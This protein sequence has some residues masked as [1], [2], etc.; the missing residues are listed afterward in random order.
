MKKPKRLFKKREAGDEDIILA[1]P[2]TWG[3]KPALLTSPRVKDLAPY[4][5]VMLAALAEGY[6]QGLEE[7][8][9]LVVWRG[10]PYAK[11]QGL[12]KS[13]DPLI[14]RPISGPEL[15]RLTGVEPYPTNTAAEAL[16]RYTFAL[17]N[18]DG[19]GPNISLDMTEEGAVL[20][21]THS[22]TYRRRIVDLGDMLEAIAMLEQLTGIGRND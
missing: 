17:A 4:G 3:E 20:A 16:P 1:V 6:K 14:F 2:S 11:E 7:P 21:W 8:C 22:R 13:A 15:E 5:T 10:S 19:I 12:E 18:E 9:V